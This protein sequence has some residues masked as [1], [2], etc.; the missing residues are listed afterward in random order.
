MKNGHL[1]Y[2][3]YVA[4]GDYRYPSALFKFFDYL[5][6]STALFL[7]FHP[8]CFHPQKVY[9]VGLTYTQANSLVFHIIND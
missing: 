4:L 1:V 3:A 7:V 6:M 8:F 2:H 5:L 9:R